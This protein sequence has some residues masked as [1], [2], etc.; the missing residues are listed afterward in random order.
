MSKKIIG[1]LEVQGNMQID[2]KYAM[3]IFNKIVPDPNTGDVKYPFFRRKEVADVL[4]MLPVSRIGT[5]DYLPINVSGSYVGASSFSQIHAIQP[6]MVEDGG[7]AVMLR[8]GTNGS[9]S[10]FYYAYVRNARSLTQLSQKDIVTTNTEFRPTIFS[11]TEKINLFYN[12]NAYDLLFYSSSDGDLLISITNGTLNELSHQ[13]TRLSASLFPNFDPLSACIIQNTVYML[14][15]DTTT[16]DGSYSKSYKMFTIPVQSVRDGNSNGFTSITGFSGRTIR[17]TTYTSSNNIKLTDRY[18]SDNDSD[19]PLFLTDGTANV[20]SD[21]VEQKKFNM[22]CV[23]DDAGTKIRI[24]IWDTFIVTSAVVSS[25]VYGYGLSVVVDLNSKVVTFDQSS[26]APIT[27]SSTNGGTNIVFNNPYAVDTTN[28]NGYPLD[29]LNGGAIGQTSDAFIVANKRRWIGDSSYGLQVLAVTPSNRFESWDLTK[30][31]AIG[32]KALNVSPV[33]GSAIGENL[34]GLRFL[35][36]NKFVVAC[37]GTANGETSNYN[38]YSSSTL[39][40]SPNYDYSSITLGSV[41]GYAPQERAM[42]GA[43]FDYTGLI[44][45]VQDDGSVSS[46]SSSFFERSIKTVARGKYNESTGTFDSVYTLSDAVLQNIKS[47]VISGSGVTDIKV[48]HL[49]LYYIPDASFGASYAVVTCVLNSNTAV[50]IYA[51][52]NLVL[53]G[54]D[55]TS[56]TVLNSRNLTVPAPQMIGIGFEDFTFMRFSNLTLAKYGSFMYLSIGATCNIT[57]PADSTF[58]AFLGKVKNNTIENS[59]LMQSSY[60]QTGGTEFGVIPGSGFGY[61]D[62]SVSD[63]QTKSIFRLCGTSESVLD[64]MLVPGVIN[65]PFTNVVLASQEVPSDYNVYVTEDVPVFLGGKFYNIPATSYNLKTIDPNPE[66]KRFYLYVQMDRSTEIASYVLTTNLLPE[67]LTSTFIGTIITG[68]SGIVSI[69]TEKVTRFLTYRPSTTK[70]G[71]AIPC[72]T[73]VP[74]GPGTR[75]N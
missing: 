22:V 55:I 27:A 38:S 28:I 53:N 25:G 10:G 24:S 44:T 49:A 41:T 74:S 72:S 63:Y 29:L 23:G 70:R 62:N 52:M 20:Y 2:S 34:L 69:S 54:N 31:T 71:S 1:S 26:T 39:S 33:F 40:S 59:K 43:N 42:I 6:I 16:I 35:T 14:G 21:N 75:W 36:K 50:I 19:K 46:Y 30:R 66:N 57:R 45:L 68:S 9:T 47:S 60:A 48:A 37:S 18:V 51:Q 12:T 4:D 73:G 7:T 15:I 17:G 58:W 11:S 64:S 65:V 67:S 5:M 13:S 8:S 3:R 56:G 32:A 61:F